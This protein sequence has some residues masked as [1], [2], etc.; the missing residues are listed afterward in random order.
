MKAFKILALIGAILFL[1]VG[2]D[3]VGW[4]IAWLPFI[5]AS[6]LVLSDK[7]QMKKWNELMEDLGA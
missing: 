5:G 4:A 1:V 3:Y 2:V 6:W 7:E